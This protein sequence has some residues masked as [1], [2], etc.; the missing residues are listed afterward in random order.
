MK[1]IYN[2]KN[3]TVA[4]AEADDLLKGATKI[5]VISYQM[6]GKEEV[7]S[8][9]KKNQYPRIKRFLNHHIENEIPIVMHNG[10]GYDV[11]LMEKILGIDLSKL[12][13]IDTLALSWYL[14]FDRKAH[15][16]DTFHEDYG[17]KK[18]VVDDWE[19]LTYEEYE[20]RCE[21]DVKINKALWEDFKERMIEIYSHSKQSI[22]DGLVGGKR[23]SEEEKIKIDEYVGDSVDEHINRI[24]TFLMFKMDCAR[25]QEKTRWEI[26]VDLL[27]TTK[28]E[29]EDH[30]ETAK[31]E[32]ESVM[33]KV[34]KYAVRKK[35]A[36]PYKKNGE[37]SKSGENWEEI[38][39]QIK[40]NEA[41]EDGNPIIRI[42]DGGVVSV[43]TSYEPPN[44][45]SPSQIKDFLFSKGWEPRTFKYVRDKEEFQKWIESK[46]MEGSS[47][48]KWTEWKDNKPVDRAVPQISIDGGD[49]KE[50]CE[51][52][53]DLAEK[54]PEILAYS[55]YTTIK[56][57]L[58]MV[59]GFIDNLEDGKWLKARI[60][61]FTNT[62]RVK[63]REIVNLPGVDKPYGKDIRGIFIAGKGRVSMG[64]DLSSL[65][66]RVKHHFMIPHDPE[67]VSTMMQDDYDAHI[68]TAHAA[69]MIDKNTLERFKA[70]DKT[71]EAVRARKS[72]KAT[73]YAS[74][75]NASP[76][77]I[78]RAAGVEL[79][80]AKKLYEGYWNLNWSVK[81]VAE[82][83]YVFEDSRNDKWLVNPI[84]G[85][86]Y[87]LRKESDRFSTLAQGTGSYIF[88]MWIDGIEE[89]MCSRYG[90]K[91]L[92][93][94]SHDEGVIIV[95]DNEKARKGIEGIVKDSL[96]SLNQ[97]LMLRRD[98]GCDVQ[99]GHRYSEIH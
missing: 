6:A 51:S 57:R 78:A 56:H 15:G 68:L 70:G 55:K 86:C 45:N 71:D 79:E 29:L 44:V 59:K 53:T 61:G 9:D 3:A 77:T 42:G 13:L 39:R 12:M 22:D 11:P 50:L 31:A 58:D 73:N 23:V 27:N 74:V 14:N 81:A 37:L 2:W 88:D 41:D 89:R 47:R 75:Y 93:Y 33:P 66:D 1:S 91:R 54:V 20:F 18:P 83:Q 67:Y 10:I 5:H 4:D 35:P 25:L 72:G 63:H 24:L 8:I 85:F 95:K 17:I 97:D 82:E 98:M 34:A 60:G 65:E 48:K 64:S 80:V 32:L 90:V 26:D 16:L 62:L 19:N 21:S 38:K 94:S 69:G 7:K 28:D 52:V 87:S 40:A 99:F 76:P 43:L 36:K 49:G 46:P 96:D 30:I 84:N 92:S